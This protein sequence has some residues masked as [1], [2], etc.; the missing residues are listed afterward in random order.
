MT[1]LYEI[2]GIVGLFRMLVYALGDVHKEYNPQAILSRVTYST[3]LIRIKQLGVDA[4]K[5]TY[6]PSSMAELNNAR[7][8]MMYAVETAKQGGGWVNAVGFCPVC[9]SFWFMLVAVLPFYG[10]F[11]FGISLLLTKICIQ[12]T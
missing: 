4:P 2:A 10:V 6:K 8:V 1:D 7:S 11:G 5:L 3:A 12:W 9:T